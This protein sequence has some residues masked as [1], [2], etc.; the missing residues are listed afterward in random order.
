MYVL[1]RRIAFESNFLGWVLMM[2]GNLA[3]RTWEREKK[4]IEISGEGEGNTII[5]EEGFLL[6]FLKSM[7]LSHRKKPHNDRS[8][9]LFYIIKYYALVADFL[10]VPTYTYIF[11]LVHHGGLF[12]H[13]NITL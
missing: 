1:V 4:G 7:Y 13:Y 6:F 9:L 5:V 12:V 3:S 10:G 2:Y 8:W 11:S